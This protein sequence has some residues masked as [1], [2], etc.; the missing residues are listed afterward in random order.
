MDKKMVGEIN[1]TGF[2]TFSSP[3]TMLVYLPF[4][5]TNQLS[6]MKNIAGGPLDCSSSIKFAGA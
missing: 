6:A 5:S 4:L 3:V 1:W 2:V